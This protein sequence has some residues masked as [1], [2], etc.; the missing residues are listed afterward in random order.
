[1][2]R[3][4][5]YSVFHL[6][7]LSSINCMSSFAIIMVLFTVFLVTAMLSLFGLTFI[8]DYLFNAQRIAPATTDGSIQ[9]LLQ[10][11]YAQEQDE[12]IDEMGD[13]DED[14]GNQANDNDSD[15]DGD[16]DD[17]QTNSVDI[18]CS[19]NERLADGMLTYKIIEEV[20]D[21][22]EDDEKNQ[23]DAEDDTNGDIYDSVS[24]LRKA[25]AD[26]IN[27]WNTKIPNLNLVEMSSTSSEDDDSKVG[28]DIEVQFIEGFGGIAAGATMISYDEDGF[29]NKATI[30]LPKAVFYIE[31]D[32]QIFAIQYDR[33]KLKEIAT[34]EMGHA[35]GLGHANFDA[36]LMSQRLSS[37]ETLNIS[38]CDVDGVLQANQWK[39]INNDNA[40]D[41]PNEDEVSC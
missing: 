4:N 6:I 31:H 25:V 18:C 7:V 26:A 1:M 30:L 23:D 10:P 15:R 8:N 12:E 17:G 9:S 34:H 13:E 21:D 5:L 35:L 3:D 38:Q 11:V 40:P 22:D 39:F 16:E 20:D 41:N 37:K 24:D 28:A 36:D 29:I 33:Q 19:W 14:D 2:S 32:S 27:E